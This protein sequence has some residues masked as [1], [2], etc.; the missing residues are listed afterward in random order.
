MDESSKHKTAFTTHRGT[1]HFNRMCFGLQGSPATFQALMTK[2]LRGIL[3]SYALCY[4]DDLICMSDTPERHLEHLTEI[5][6]RFRSANL[7]L[8]PQKCQFALP[9]VTYLGHVLSKEG[10]SVDE[11]KVSVIKTFPVPTNSQQLRSYLGIAN[12]YRR[13]IKHFSIKTA[14]LRSLLKRDAKFV[15]NSVH[16]KV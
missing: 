1:Y 14:N 15:W 12:L 4:I 5:F 7:R 6:D 13:F 2:V 10:E 16:Q 9:K 3:F 11:S 8:N